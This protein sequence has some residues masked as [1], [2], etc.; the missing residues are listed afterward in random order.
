MVVA[1]VGMLTALVRRQS[2]LF[3]CDEQTLLDKVDNE[4]FSQYSTK[5]LKTTR[6]EVEGIGE[7]SPKVS[8]LERE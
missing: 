7:Q 6:I 2:L 4:F 8:I 1:F 5:L 3:L